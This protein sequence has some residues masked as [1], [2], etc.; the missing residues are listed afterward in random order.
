[1]SV[2]L[3]LFAHTKFE[4]I[5]QENSLIIVM[6]HEY[7]N[8]QMKPTSWSK[9]NWNWNEFEKNLDSFSLTFGLDLE[10]WI[11]FDPLRLNRELTLTPSDLIL[12][13]E[14]ALTP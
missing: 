9:L 4:L 12:N 14:M 2:L 11:G 3:F 7:M 13:L 10:S 5:L 1:M 8:T 6:I